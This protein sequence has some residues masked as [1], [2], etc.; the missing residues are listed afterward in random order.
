MSNVFR[1]G[2]HICALYDTE[3][4]RV[5]VAAEYVVD[6]LRRGER[7]YYVAES[8]EAIDRLRGALRRAG[9][10]VAETVMRGALIEA[11]HDE[12]HLK[13]GRFDSERMLQLLNDAVEL[14]MLDGFTGLRT[15]GDMSWLLLDA[16]GSAQVVEY[17]SFLNRFFEGIPAQ[18]MCQ[19]D[20]RRLPPDLIGHALATHPSAV[21]KRRYAANTLYRPVP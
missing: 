10:D 21:L 13:D 16:P 2:D 15:C 17:E 14:A 8:R 4:E 7:C 5:A 3:E 18:G 6:G 20:R 19:Y 1:Q 12:A 11:T 9:I